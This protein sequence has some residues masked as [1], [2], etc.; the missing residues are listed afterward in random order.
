MVCT[1]HIRPDVIGMLA[2]GLGIARYEVTQRPDWTKAMRWY[3]KSKPLLTS[4]IGKYLL[5]NC[6]NLT[7]V[8]AENF[9]EALRLYKTSYGVMP[10]T[11]W[12]FIGIQC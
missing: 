2:K 10:R 5:I 11:G 1:S 8:S 9:D 4:H 7:H 12:H 3:E 6:D